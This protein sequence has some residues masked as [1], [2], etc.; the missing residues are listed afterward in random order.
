MEI[1]IKELTKEIIMNEELYPINPNYRPTVIVPEAYRTLKHKPFKLGDYYYLQAPTP[2]LRHLLDNP[3]GSLPELLSHIF[4][5]THQ[6]RYNV[7]PTLYKQLTDLLLF[8]NKMT[9]SSPAYTINL[10]FR[11]SKLAGFQFTRT[12]NDTPEG[13]YFMSYYNARIT[14]KPIT[15]VYAITNAHLISVI[16]LLD[17]YNRTGFYVRTGYTTQARKAI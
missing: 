2:A 10:L 7:F 12:L 17:E 6:S 8:T 9:N 13:F 11:E 3:T 15:A 14:E 5:R 4:N 1:S 16:N